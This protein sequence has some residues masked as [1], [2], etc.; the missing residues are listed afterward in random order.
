MFVTIAVSPSDE[1]QEVCTFRESVFGV[2]LG[3]GR[4]A[5]QGLQ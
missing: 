4:F 5:N 3:A 1:A 2:V